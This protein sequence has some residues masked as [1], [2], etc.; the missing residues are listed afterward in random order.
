MKKSVGLL[1]LHVASI[2]AFSKTCVASDYVFLVSRFFRLGMLM[3]ILRIDYCTS[4][5][6]RVLEV[7]ESVVSIDL[8]RQVAL[9]SRMRNDEK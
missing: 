1:L 4:I 7:C 3:I 2:G 9:R 8:R 6:N 5:L